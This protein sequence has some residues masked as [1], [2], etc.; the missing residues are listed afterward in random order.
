M[1]LLIC[2][3]A[4]NAQ[5]REA[6]LGYP[7]PASEQDALVPVDV[8]PINIPPAAPLLMATVRE[9]LSGSPTFRQMVEVLRKAPH[10]IVLLRPSH[11]LGD[12]RGRGRLSVDCGKIVG[13]FE[14]PD[15]D[16]QERLAA[17]A[18]E[19]AHAVEVA[20]LP[21]VCELEDLHRLLLRQAGLP[22]SRRRVLPI[23]TPF[24]QFAGQAVIDELAEHD[25]KSGQLAV[26]AARYG[27][28]LFDD[29]PA[30]SGG[31]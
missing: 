15:G 26:I 21:P 20:G 17:V 19:I 12:L 8:R 16:L 30:E 3:P 14:I 18:H 6:T 1:W 22:L 29:F 25:K 2:P 5:P 4:T 13:V 23:E 9:L 7:Q 28:S 11:N 24:A 31:T 27:L 10:V